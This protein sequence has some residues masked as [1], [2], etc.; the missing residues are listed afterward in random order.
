MVERVTRRRFGRL[1]RCGKHQLSSRQAERIAL[2]RRAVHRLVIRLYF[3]ETRFRHKEMSMVK[4]DRLLESLV[5]E[6][7]DL[8]VTRS[9]QERLARL[10]S[11]FILG[12]HTPVSGLHPRQSVFQIRHAEPDVID[13]SAFASARWWLL[14]LLQ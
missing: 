12:V 14:P 11:R 2:S 7:L 3:L 1:L 13:H 4:Y 5:F 9:Q 6:K 8:H 10:C